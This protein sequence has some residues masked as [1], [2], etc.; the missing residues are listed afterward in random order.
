MRAEIQCPA[1]GDS[2]TPATRTKTLIVSRKVQTFV[3]N[4][5]VC[6]RCGNEYELSLLKQS[7]ETNRSLFLW[8][9]PA[10]LLIALAIF[11]LSTAQSGLTIPG[12]D[13]M[14]SRRLPGYRFSQVLGGLSA[15]IGLLILNYLR[16]FTPAHR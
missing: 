13:A 4:V 14:F 5:A 11:L 12:V 10:I 16:D 15:L 1:C 9:A 7:P 2:Y 8:L 6:R 3:L